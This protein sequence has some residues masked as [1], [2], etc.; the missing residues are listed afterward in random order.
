MKAV[1]AVRQ[2]RIETTNGDQLAAE[3]HRARGAE[4]A[5]PRGRPCVVMAHGVGATRDCGLTEFAE[6]LSAAGVDVL[7]FDY[8]HFAKSSGSPRQL[9]DL[10]THNVPTTTAPSPSHG[11]Y[12]VSMPPASW[13][14]GVSLSGGH[15]L[16]VAAQDP[17]LAG[18]ISLTAAVD[19]LAAITQ[20]LRA[21]GVAHIAKLVRAGLADSIAAVRGRP[22]VLAPVV[23]RPGEVAALCS[24]SAVDGMLDIAGPSWRNAIAAR[25]FLRIG[26]YRPIRS[27]KAIACPVLMQI[28]DGDQSAPPHAAA[29]A[30]HRVRA[31]VHHYPCDH[32]DVYPGA[33]HH[34]RVVRHQIAFLHRVLSPNSKA[35]NA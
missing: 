23:G 11:R 33:T 29:A 24:P 26:T 34:D 8:R 22:P 4:L 21:N 18:V 35:G 31:A 20:M 5:G 25:I 14:G 32:F 2:V 3:H 1:H 30:A 28:A 16:R 17:E 7:A 19:G 13:R 15:V 12:R 10:H 27:A 6:A 9:V